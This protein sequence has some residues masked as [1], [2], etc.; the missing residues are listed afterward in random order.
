MNQPSVNISSCWISGEK[1]TLTISEASRY[2]SIGIKRL[3]RLAE[4]HLG[5]FAVFSGNKSYG[6]GLVTDYDGEHITVEFTNRSSSF[7]MPQ[8]FETGFL[9]SEYPDFLSDIKKMME[10]NRRIVY[11]RNE[12]EIRKDKLDTLV[13]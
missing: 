11:I 12:I 8:A 7:Q 13:I 4:E 10:V 1:Y 2:Y 6:E 5:N 3:R 9:Q